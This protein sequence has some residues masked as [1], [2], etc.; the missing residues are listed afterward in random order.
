[1]DRA[2]GDDV[3]RVGILADGSS[4]TGMTPSDL[5]PMS[6]ENLVMLDLND[7]AVNQIRP[8]RNR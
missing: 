2:E 8:R 6:H 3:C 5:N 1:M 7:G 4:R